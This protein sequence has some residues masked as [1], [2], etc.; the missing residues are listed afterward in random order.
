MDA[1]AGGAAGDGGGGDLKIPWFYT[2]AIIFMTAIGKAGDALAPSL[3][4]ASPLW[5]LCLNSND[6]HLGAGSTRGAA[7]SI[8]AAAACSATPWGLQ[9]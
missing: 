2:A 5:L 1:P 6:L 9:G 7:V 8:A 4:T 3:L